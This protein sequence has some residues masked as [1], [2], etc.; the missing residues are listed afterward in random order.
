MKQVVADE[1]DQGVTKTNGYGLRN[2]QAALNRIE[3]ESLMHGEVV[4]L[5]E[6]ALFIKSRR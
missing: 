5:A 1:L 4:S 2:A 6:Y 3:F